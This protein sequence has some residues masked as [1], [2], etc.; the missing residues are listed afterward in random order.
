MNSSPFISASSSTRSVMIDVIIAL[1]PL[2]VI[3]LW[4]FGERAFVVVISCILSCLLV[5]V[6]SGYVILNKSKVSMDGSAI[7]T[8][9]LLAF[10]LSP[11]TPWYVC[12]FGGSMAILF[13]KI[14]W[15]GLGKNRFNPALVGREFMTAFFPFIM[16]GGSLWDT[17]L[18]VNNIDPGE[19]KI[20]LSGHF[21]T[22]IY[23]P[24]GALGEYSLVAISL[25][26]IY[27]LIRN[28]ISWH[29]PFTFLVTLSLVQSLL[30]IGN[31]IQFSTG[32]VLLGAVFMATDMPTSP[33]HRNAKLYFGMMLGLVISLL[34]YSGVH[35]VYL[36]YGI[37]IMN[38]FMK[39]IGEVM[40][41]N[42]WG[43][44]F[45]KDT[46]EKIGQTSFHILL[47]TFS[48]ISLH[49]ADVINWLI[50]G[51]AGYM[52]FKFYD[53]TQFKTRALF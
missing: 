7:I 20:F 36:S 27:L 34:L 44:S 33:T 28:R 43:H 6:L 49:K 1:L 17:G 30:P 25:G 18:Y 12:V 10:T 37:L 16:N 9:I 38:A 13:G 51:Y 8:G 46:L 31:T 39:Q 2:L 26:G 47:I 52:L 15:G 21:S 5:N 29:I 32:G 40:K 14:L 35:H 3:A 42:A 11:L 22:I 19:Y 45:Q 48:V 50:F 53:Q 4:A 23:N 41:P 24:T